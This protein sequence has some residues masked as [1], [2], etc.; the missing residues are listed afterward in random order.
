MILTSCEYYNKSLSDFLEYYTQTATIGRIETPEGTLKDKTGTDCLSSDS[1]KT[2][3]IYLTN[4]QKYE[5]NY[6]FTFVNDLYDSS[7]VYITQISSN[8]S[9]MHLTFPEEFLKKHEAGAP[10]GGTISIQESE[11]L[12]DF[13]EFSFS[14][15]CNSAPPSVLGL[16]VQ[17]A[18]K[19]TDPEK[20][21]YVLCFY[22]P[23]GLL[24]KSPHDKDKH[25]IHIND[26]RYQVWDNF[27][28]LIETS[29]PE[30]LTSAVEDGAIF[31]G[32]TIP[33]EGYTVC[34]YRTGVV[35]TQDVV[36]YTVYLE[37][38]DGLCS[39]ISR[40]S[41]QTEKLS[42]PEFSDI[43]GIVISGSTQENPETIAIEETG[44]AVLNIK[45]PGTTVTESTVSDV[46]VCYTII[47]DGEESSAKK[48]IAPAQI[49]IS[50]AGT[51]TV[52]AYAEKNHYVESDGVV[53]Y[54]KVKPL[55][56]LYVGEAGSDETG[57]GSISK[58][59]ASVTKAA[60]VVSAMEDDSE[61]DVEIYVLGTIN[62]PQTIP[63]SITPSKARQITISNKKTVG[64]LDGNNEGSALTINT[65]VPVLIKNITITGGSAVN[66]GG[67]YAASGSN[68]T[69][70]EGSVIAG[71][72][73]SS[74]GGGIYT[75]GTL[76]LANGSLIGDKN[77]TVYAEI[78]K[79]S[80][81][82]N[83]GGGVYFETGSVTIETGAM[84]AY[85]YA[86]QGGGIAHT[87]NSFVENITLNLSGGEIAYNGCQKDVQNSF[88][89][90]LY[91]AGCSFNF[92][93]G[94][95]YGNYADHGGGGIFLQS[96]S[97]A[98][99]TGGTICN[100]NY[101]SGGWKQGTEI[102]LYKD[103]TFSMSGGFIYRDTNTERGVDVMQS[104]S[105]LEMSGS[106]RIDATTPVLLERKN[107]KITIA[108]DLT[109]SGTVATI[110]LLSQSEY[111]ANATKNRTWTVGEQILVASS[112]ELI[113]NN[114]EHFT[115]V[116]DAF[117]I[118]QNGTGT[119]A[120]LD[121]AI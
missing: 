1:D 45:H 68:V 64:V 67:I 85:N 75:E 95:I 62:G 31:D 101:S 108:G 71:N 94:S 13:G 119:S 43:D 113:S 35:P 27:L 93:E 118:T 121:D 33:A 87:G 52:T 3:T 99:M 2:I 72:K 96:T 65:S 5:L 23:K 102:L 55:S 92:T 41:N 47:K 117:T 105:N 12:R 86:Y 82:A 89:G 79:H 38:Y 54:I 61:R 109:S 56:K 88:G 18:P 103:C 84:I 48:I 114:I 69:L 15:K 120:V 44:Y 57:T 91:I 107:T 116:D 51:Y 42:P 74:N 112:S 21:E 111:L 14:L 30:G 11:T 46:S 97:H 83:L 115:T 100:N 66:G 29:A 9:L 6:T 22:L 60:S 110:T 53:Q 26:N 20:K 10:I 106:A 63:A 50:E 16:M 37:D 70:G 32:E 76:L 39:K 81:S 104:S 19:A 28:N 59:F 80:N 4:P 17:T 36:T 34:Y 24:E 58:P 25:Y 90:G 49:K 98:E 8:R 40:V 78:D 77:K 7:S 73:A